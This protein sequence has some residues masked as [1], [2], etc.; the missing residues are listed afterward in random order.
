ML[1]GN[2]LSTNEKTI[3]MDLL[4]R[5]VT[6]VDNV[7][8][9]VGEPYRRG[10]Q[11]DAREFLSALL[12]KL[13]P[14]R[15]SCLTTFLAIDT[16]DECGWVTQRVEEAEPIVGLDSRESSIRDLLLRHCESSPENVRQKHCERCS[17]HQVDYKNHSTTRSVWSQNGILLFFARRFQIMGNI[18][19]MTNEHIQPSQRIRL[20]TVQ[21]GMS[22]SRVKG[23]ITDGKGHKKEVR[24]FL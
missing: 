16:C 5:R 18:Q 17:L 11:D 24:E 22:G 20:E 14:F 6:S 19:R 7:L 21:Q 8:Q 12:D 2:I 9:F 1:A 15:H 3:F 13:P 4:D 10:V 23:C